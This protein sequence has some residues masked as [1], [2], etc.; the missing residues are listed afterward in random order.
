LGHQFDIPWTKHF[1][2]ISGKVLDGWSF[3]GIFTLQ[4]G[5]PVTLFSGSQT[6]LSNVPDPKHP[7]KFLKQS[8]SDV[9]ILGLPQPAGSSTDRV[10]GNPTLLHPAP[11]GSPAADLIRANKPFTQPLLGNFGTSPRNAL[12][13]SNLTD[14][15]W[16]LY[17]TTKLTEKT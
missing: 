11:S 14:F 13:L 4:T 12:R 2:G 6:A 3:N 10:N 1:T 8:I 5:F 7:G 16:G 9:A 17:K 15:D